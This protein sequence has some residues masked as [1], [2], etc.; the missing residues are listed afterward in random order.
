[1]AAIA[2]LPSPPASP[3]AAA[4]LSPETT[5]KTK[6]AHWAHLPLGVPLAKDAHVARQVALGELD[7]AAG[8]VGDPAAAR[9]QELHNLAVVAAHRVLE[10]RALEAVD[11]VDAGAAVVEQPL[12]DRVAAL[13]RGEVAGSF[14]LAFVFEE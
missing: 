7:E 14:V 10:R 3:T 11:G 1:M 6:R 5:N 12:G 8:L 4:F 9:H 13:G 2:A